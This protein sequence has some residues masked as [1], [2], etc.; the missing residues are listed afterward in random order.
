MSM[1][2]ILES[3]WS[4]RTVLTE[5]VKVKKFHHAVKPLTKKSI[6]VLK[7]GDLFDLE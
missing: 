2:L 1:W 6:I 5:S 7:E 4:K 3:I